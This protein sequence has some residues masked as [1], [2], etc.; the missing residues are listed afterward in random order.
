MRQW[1]A[2]LMLAFCGLGA[3]QAHGATAG[4]D[5]YTHFFN[6]SFGDFK[7]ELQNARDQGKK[8]VMIFF[9]MDECPFCH[10]MKQHVLNQP[11]VQA[12]YRDNFL[13]FSVDI[14]GDLE[15]TDFHGKPM[16]QKDFAF[17][18]YRVRATPVIAFF[19]LDGNEVHRYT[20]RTSGV[21][22]FMWLGQYVAE[23]HYRETSFTRFKRQMRKR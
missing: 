16:K 3:L 5:P 11:E 22:E 13:L 2:W 7:E 10:Y 14:E 1:V 20:G 12:Y 18:E 15:I 23:G 4:R 19:D 21:E 8:G 17:K 6:E 9:E